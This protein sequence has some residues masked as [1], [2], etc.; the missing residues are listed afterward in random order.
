MDV[1]RYSPFQPQDGETVLCCDHVL[2]WWEGGRPT[3]KLHWHGLD[4]EDGKAPLYIEGE[5]VNLKTG[6]EEKF[7]A[8][9][10]CVC[11][12]CELEGDLDS[13]VTNDFE[14]DSSGPI[15]EVEF[16]A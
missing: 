11:P 8:R 2:S 14:Y 10:A 6:R 15:I 9:F 16:V 3:Q 13:T 7:R 1:K 4:T 12:E 5:K